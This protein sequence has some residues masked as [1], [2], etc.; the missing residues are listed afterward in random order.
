[1][2]SGLTN[3]WAW[4]ERYEALRQCF[5]DESGRLACAPLGLLLLIREGLAGWMRRWNPEAPV[6]TGSAKCPSL[7]PLMPASGWQCELTYLLARITTLHLEPCRS[8]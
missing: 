7:M 3:D 5:V 8:P 6:S 2:S 1:M 4:T